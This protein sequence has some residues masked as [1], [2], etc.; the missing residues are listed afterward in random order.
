MSREICKKAAVFFNYIDLSADPAVF[1]RGK[2]KDG[3]R[4][5]GSIKTASKGEIT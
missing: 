3:K 2:P 1:R 4:T 5:S